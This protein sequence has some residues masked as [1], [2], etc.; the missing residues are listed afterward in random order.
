M[1]CAV[2]SWRGAGCCVWVRVKRYW[3]V[4]VKNY[5][6]FAW[7]RLVVVR[8]VTCDRRVVMFYCTEVKPTAIIAC[9]YAK[10]SSWL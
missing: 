6:S 7:A 1:V 8:A 3:M 10:V 2:V 5:I 9:I 4:V